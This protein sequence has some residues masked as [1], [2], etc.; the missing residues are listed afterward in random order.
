ML[1][2]TNKYRYNTLFAVRLDD[3]PRNSEEAIEHAKH[4]NCHK[5]IDLVE[6]HLPE[7]FEWQT[8]P[9]GMNNEATQYM[10]SVFVLNAE[11]L[12]EI[13]RAHGGEIY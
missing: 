2:M 12:K 3:K 13:V 4:L 9:V 8:Q 10:T 6:S 1:A 7:T 5:I 11:Q